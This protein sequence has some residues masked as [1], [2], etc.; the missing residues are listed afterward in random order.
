MHA[1]WKS[2]SRLPVW[3]LLPP[4]DTRAIVERYVLPQG[5]EAR[6]QQLHLQNRVIIDFTPERGLFRA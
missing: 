4:P 3:S 6:M 5:V 1:T 2:F